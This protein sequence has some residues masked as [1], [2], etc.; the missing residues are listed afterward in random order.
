MTPKRLVLPRGYIEKNDFAGPD[1]LTVT[2]IFD[3]VV[4][5][6]RDR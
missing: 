5:E 2:I 6:T 4:L 3:G 1:E